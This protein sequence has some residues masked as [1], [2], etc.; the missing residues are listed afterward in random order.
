MLVPRVA[1]LW[2][3]GRA[4]A[5]TATVAV[6]IIEREER[7][8]DSII[9]VTH[10][11]QAK[12]NW[13]WAACSEMMAKRCEGDTGP[14]QSRFAT[15]HNEKFGHGL[16][17]QASAT[18]AAWLLERYANRN[19]DALEVGGGPSPKL[20]WGVLT[21]ALGK[22]RMAILGISG[23]DWLAVGFGTTWG[24]QNFLW[25]HNPASESGPDRL[26]WG[27]IQSGWRTTLIMTK[28]D[29]YGLD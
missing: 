23:H 14:D 5:G 15:L 25:A 17:H 9:K 2:R 21:D 8:P 12:S 6:P 3:Q 24:G 4:V 29:I 22:V 13:C 26:G 10:V 19:V 20:S 7:V 27:A 18:E 11:K 1:W 16:N 28:H